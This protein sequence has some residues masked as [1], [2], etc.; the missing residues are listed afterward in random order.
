MCLCM[1][2]CNTQYF[3]NIVILWDKSRP[4]PFTQKQTKSAGLFTCT[5]CLQY[6]A[7]CNIHP[8]TKFKWCIY[9]RPSNACCDLPL[10]LIKIELL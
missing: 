10:R 7:G 9:S 2:L 5:A 3:I 6:H 1:Y 4:L 8:I